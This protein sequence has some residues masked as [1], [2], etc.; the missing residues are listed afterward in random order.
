MLP[1]ILNFSNNVRIE[2]TSGHRT[3]W[4]IHS[5]SPVTHTIK[6]VS[7]RHA[8][9]R[10]NGL[11]VLGRW[12][13]HL[14]HSGADVAG[15]VVENCTVRDGGSFA[16]V[17]HDTHDVTFLR[18][19]GHNNQ[20]SQFWWD[21][22]VPADVSNNISYVD[23]VASKTLTGDAGDGTSQLRL[24]AFY[25]DRNGTGHSAVG[26][27]AVGVTVG[28][29][30][31]S[32]FFWP[33]S[34]T[35]NTQGSVEGQWV[36]TD[37]IAHNN[38]AMGIFAWQNTG[39]EVQPDWTGYRSYQNGGPGTNSG[40]YGFNVDVLDYVAYRDGW[41]TSINANSCVVKQSARRFTY[42]GS[43]L[44]GGGK[45]LWGIVHQEA[46][47]FPGDFCTFVDPTIRG[48]QT[49]AVCI[50][51]PFPGGTAHS[52]FG[53]DFVRPKIGD[54]DRDMIP[55]DIVLQ[56]GNPGD[57]IRVQ[58]Q[59]DATAW[60]WELVGSPPTVS[61]TEIAPFYPYP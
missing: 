16:F 37:C 47:G 38:A 7:V 52:N 27:I 14:H 2:G 5:D 46:T 34:D 8:G 48:Y 12:P 4:Y 21:H 6:N 60:Q 55:S 20:E 17:S 30:S 59:G 54:T 11:R 45:P 18:C 19:V 28:N 1:E 61:I 40:A 26:C 33:E 13:I 44:D 36:F 23:C 42:F 39:F 53:I 31:Q 41:N 50:Q 49:A 3:H 22:D 51:N 9:P 24:S 35:A 25:L 29:K 58:R 32:G 57:R 43:L 10:K 15:L 56:S